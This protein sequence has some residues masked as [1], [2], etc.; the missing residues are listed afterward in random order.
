MNEAGRRPLG[1]QQ[2]QDSRGDGEDGDGGMAS[3]P[4]STWRRLTLVFWWFWLVTA[5]IL[6]FLPLGFVD[7][8]P[9]ASATWTRYSAVLCTVFTLARA[10]SVALPF[11]GPYQPGWSVFLAVYAYL[12]MIKTAVITVVSVSCLRESAM[13]C[14][15]VVALRHSVALQPLRRSESWARLAAVNAAFFVSLVLLPIIGFTIFIDNESTQGGNDSGNP[16][17]ISYLPFE[18]ATIGTVLNYCDGQITILLAVL[19]AVFCNEAAVLWVLCTELRL[20]VTGEIQRVSPD[21]N[22]ILPVPPTALRPLGGSTGPGPESLSIVSYASLSRLSSWSVALDSES[23][24]D[25]AREEGK[26]EAVLPSTKVEAVWSPGRVEVEAACSPAW[27]A[28]PG[29]RSESPAFY[30]CPGSAA[31]WRQIRMRLLRLHDI[32]AAMCSAYGWSNLLS[33]TISLIDG[34]LSIFEDVA[35]FGDPSRITRPLLST[36]WG[37]IVVG[38]FVLVCLV[39][40]Q[41]QNEHDALKHLLSGYLTRLPDLPFDVKDEVRICVLSFLTSRVEP[42]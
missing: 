38:K 9:R 7:Q 40:Q 18:P 30:V 34:S 33:I 20:D 25:S 3:R 37:L 1:P 27:A 29:G 22:R 21:V 10:L 35:S 6:G 2:I 28:V 26:V 36:M 11:L 17:D 14:A 15:V 4:E 32:R 31:S 23:D 24:K 8:L 39:C 41:V 12:V 5:R 19:D 42:R 16:A 13:Q